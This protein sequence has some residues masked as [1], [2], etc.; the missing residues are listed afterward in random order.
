MADD[1]F[2]LPTPGQARIFLIGVDD[3]ALIVDDNIA[4]VRHLNEPFVFFLTLPEF[5]LGLSALGNVAHDDREVLEGA[6]G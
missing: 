4:G 2:R 6:V 3:P 5:H 1:L